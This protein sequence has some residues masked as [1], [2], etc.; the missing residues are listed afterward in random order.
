MELLIKN[1]LLFIFLLTVLTSKSFAH[2]KPSLVDGADYPLA[3]QVIE[4]KELC[5]S[6]SG[7]PCKA[8]GTEITIEA[9]LD[10]CADQVKSF[11]YVTYLYDG[12]LNV[13]IESMARKNPIASRVNCADEQKFIQVIRVIEE[14]IEAVNLKNIHTQI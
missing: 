5:P 12:K 8:V 2:I 10:H 3:Y 14:N 7:Y 6:Q 1:T 11:D 4:K 9:T 13:E